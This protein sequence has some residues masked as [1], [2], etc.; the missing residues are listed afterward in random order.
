PPMLT[1]T[2]SGVG[3][4]NNSGTTQNFVTASEPGSDGV[5]QFTNSATAGSLTTFTNNSGTVFGSPRGTEFFNTSTAG[6][7][8]FINNGS[9]V[10]GALGGVTEFD[11][12]TT[13]GTARVEVFGNGV[14]GDTTNGNLDISFHNAP[15]VTV[16]SIEGNGAVFL[17]AFNLTVGSNNLSTTFSGVIQDGGSNGGILGSF[18]KIGMGKLTLSKAS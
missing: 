16:G 17:G 2:I 11:A 14:A 4:T 3:I 1:L 18:T 12:S 7:G 5:I 15:G 10:S 8:T 9:A 13:G 6:N